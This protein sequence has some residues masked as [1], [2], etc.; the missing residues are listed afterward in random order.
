[1][2]KTST[3]TSKRQLTIPSRI[4]RAVGFSEGQKVIITHKNGSIIVQPS[5]QLVERLAGSVKIPI[6]FRSMSIDKMIERA[7]KEYY[8]H[9]V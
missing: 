2:E 4:F 8:Q 5:S 9:R 7:K 6:R 3:I 1:M